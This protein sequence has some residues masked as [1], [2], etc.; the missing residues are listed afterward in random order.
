MRGGGT[1]LR[2]ETATHLDVGLTQ[3]LTR[4]TT[5]QA[6]WYARDERDVLWPRGAEPRRLSDGTITTGRAD[7]RWV[8]ALDGRARGIELVLRRDAPARL[9]G[10]AGY[11]YGRH[12]YTDVATGERF[13]ADADQRHTLSLYG[14][15][16]FSHR[17][18]I[19]AKFRYGSNYP[20]VGYIG[21]Q[22]ASGGA[23]LPP[24]FGDGAAPLFH[25]LIEQRNGL[26]LPAYARLDVRADRTFTW[27]SRRVTVFAE[28][29]NALN[30]R[31]LRNV[32]Y[33]SI[34][35]GVFPG[36]PTRSCRSSPR[37]DSLWS[38]KHTLLAAT[39]IATRGLLRAGAARDASRPDFHPS[40]RVR[41][42]AGIEERVSVTF[43]LHAD[44]AKVRRPAQ[45]AERSD[46]HMLIPLAT[47]LVLSMTCQSPSTDRDLA[48][49]LARSGRTVE[50]LAIFE[51]IVA[52]NPTDVEVRLWIA[53]LQLRMGRTEEAE[54]GFRAV[55]LEHP[56][57]VDARIG[58]GAALTRRDAWR[59]ALAVLLDAE[60]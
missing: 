60:Q 12:R 20:L 57:D 59:E 42:L 55:L 14:S 25:Q 50:A 47:A 13:D 49:Q 53:R 33:G 2:H 32:P 35:R 52:E 1:A 37:P 46:E 4:E 10:L 56:S 48:E 24:L 5:L 40:R 23:P 36:R 34:V 54:A 26:R 19:G 11:A 39:G 51:R 9:S 29:A 8:N 7:A 38:S 58:L 31:N 30:R 43:E 15:Y 45:G 41:S 16:R 17:S 28:V 27:S 21:E 3:Q 18:T 6:T 44:V 22:R